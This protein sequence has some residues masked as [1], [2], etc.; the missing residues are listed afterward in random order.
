MLLTNGVIQFPAPTF[1]TVFGRIMTSVPIAITDRAE[2]DCR[3]LCVLLP[4][5]DFV[6]KDSVGSVRCL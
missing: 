3:L 5:V 2:V 4:Y 1:E 6:A